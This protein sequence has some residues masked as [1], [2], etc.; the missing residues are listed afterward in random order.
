MIHD[1]CPSHC[2]RGRSKT[3]GISS[4]ASTVPLHMFFFSVNAEVP[5]ATSMLKSNFIYVSLLYFHTFI[6][7]LFFI[8]EE[9]V[10]LSSEKV[11]NFIYEPAMYVCIDTYSLVTKD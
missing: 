2:S 7:I 10:I 4:H 8:D 6:Y 9:L 11:S 1:N 5:I 3:P